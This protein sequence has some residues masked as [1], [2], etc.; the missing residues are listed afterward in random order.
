MTPKAFSVRGRHDALGSL[1]LEHRT[2]SKIG[3]SDLAGQD[4]LLS[5][6]STLEAE[7]RLPSGVTVIT[8]W[9][10]Y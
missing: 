10:F 6:S 4:C 1:Y 7:G 3:L 9:R 8:R 5:P 2:G